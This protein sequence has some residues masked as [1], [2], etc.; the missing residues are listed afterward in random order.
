[1]KMEKSKSEYNIVGLGQHQG[2][3]PDGD[4]VTIKAIHSIE[5]NAE[6]SEQINSKKH[7]IGLSGVNITETTNE[8]VDSLYALTMVLPED[9]GKLKPPKF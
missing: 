9:I 6:L 5:A 8:G 3:G 7:Y 2:S 1:M 4:Q